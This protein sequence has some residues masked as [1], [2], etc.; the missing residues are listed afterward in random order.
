MTP[1]ER[2]IA[3]VQRL[4]QIHGLEMWD[5]PAKTR[6]SISH[7]PIDNWTM[8][9]GDPETRHDL[10]IDSGQGEYALW[11]EAERRIADFI[12]N[13]RKDSDV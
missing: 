7:P 13:G 4:M 2:Q 6:I 3:K 9:I 5:A 8:R 1:L 10:F 12:S 11:C